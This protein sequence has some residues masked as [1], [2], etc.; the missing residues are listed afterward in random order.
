MEM[1]PSSDI[2][3]KRELRLP[4]GWRFRPTD[5]EL[6]L[7]YLKNRV[8]NLPLPASVIPELDVFQ[9]HPSDF[10]GDLKEKRYFFSRRKGN[11]RKCIRASSGSG[12][13]RVVGKDR[14]FVAHSGCNMA[15][16]MKKSLVFHEAKLPCGTNSASKTTWVMH[17]YSLVNCTGPNP[18]S[19]QNPRMDREEWL[20][21]CIFQEKKKKKKSKALGISSSSKRTVNMEANSA[22]PTGE[23]SCELGSPQP[24]SSCSSGITEVSSHGNGSEQ[25]ES[26]GYVSLSS[27]S[28][29]C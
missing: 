23:N 8:S 20:V 6:I 17:E 2:V 19:T 1:K 12:Y 24:S 7:H 10:P 3:Q 27:F 13:W 11:G 14:L 29:K 5:E 22:F 18:N 9:T 26:S 16:A 15:V 28:W 4:I 21:Y 25:E